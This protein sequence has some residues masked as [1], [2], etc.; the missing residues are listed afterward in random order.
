MYTELIMKE[1]DMQNLTSSDSCSFPFLSP[2]H[3]CPFTF[4]GI[5]V[6]PY[7]VAGNDPLQKNNPLGLVKRQQLLVY[8]KTLLFPFISEIHLMNTGSSV[9]V[10]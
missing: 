2:L 5:M 8:L 6:D 4:W 9:M 7:L 3:S 10:P 1:L